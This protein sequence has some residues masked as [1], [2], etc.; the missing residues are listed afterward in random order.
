[1]WITTPLFVRNLM[2]LSPARRQA[3]DNEI[4][5]ARAQQEAEMANRIQAECPGLSRDVALRFAARS[6]RQQEAS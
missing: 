4:S 2:G 5:A 1:M 6:I 3:R